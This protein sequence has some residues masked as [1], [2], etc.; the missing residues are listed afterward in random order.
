MIAITRD[1]SEEIARCELTYL[2]RAPIDVALA[3]AQHDG[4]CR[5]LEGLG[6][7]VVRLPALPGHP[8]ACFVEDAAVVFDE[9]AIMTHMGA[10][11]RRGE[12]AT[13]EAALREHRPIRRVAA[14]ATI[15]GGDVL[16]VGRDVF[17]G[18][19]LRTNEGGVRGL[20]EALAPFGYD[21]VGVD[22]T[23]C[24]HLKS[25]AT[26]IDDRAVLV[27]ADWIDPATFDGREVVR[28]PKDEPLAANVLRVGD[29]LVVHDGFP[30]TLAML[31]RRGCRLVPV[32][33]SE[34]IKTEAAVT[35]KS[36]LFERV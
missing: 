29:R 17:V 19:T 36:L 34:F 7:E 32:D 2:D 5:A 9:L 18:R 12:S 11:S 20:R 14:P 6:V 28:V 35:C 24:L 33:V 8:D 13:L 22:V 26:A 10:P 23:G 21:V 15:D 1:V 3:I 16:V 27:N 31:E 30:R 25:A 4:Y